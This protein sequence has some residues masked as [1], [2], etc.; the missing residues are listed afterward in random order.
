M[1]PVRQ[2]FTLT[3]RTAGNAGAL[4]IAPHQLAGIQVRGIARQ[5]IQRQLPLEFLDVAANKT[6][7]V[8]GQAVEHEMQRPVP[9]FHHLAEQFDETLAAASVRSLRD[10]VDRLA[11]QA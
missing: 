5:K 6:A 3:Q 1:H 11:A 8:G 4:G 10:R 9:V 7:L 2:F